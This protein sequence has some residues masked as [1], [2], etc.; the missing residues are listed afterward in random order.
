[1]QKAGISFW[2]EKLCYMKTGAFI[3]YK[4]IEHAV[5]QVT[6][7]TC[8]DQGCTNYKTSVVFFAEEIAENKNTGN[9]CNQP[10]QGKR[11]FTPVSTQFPTPGHP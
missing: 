9:Y 3:K 5:Y 1:M 7:C 10:E 6:Q 11:H 4:P 8:K 2:G